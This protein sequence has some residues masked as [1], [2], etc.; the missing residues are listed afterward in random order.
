MQSECP[1]RLTVGPR[2]ADSVLLS[3]SPSFPT[4]V[5]CLLGYDLEA[6]PWLLD[7]GVFCAWFVE[8]TG[9][10]RVVDLFQVLHGLVLGVFQ[11]VSLS[12]Q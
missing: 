9:D 10:G 5:V 3:R 7:V 2:V 11:E 8:S 1:I 12:L 6:P 4:L